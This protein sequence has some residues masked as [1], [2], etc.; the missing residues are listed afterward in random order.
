MESHMM[1][2]GISLI[3]DYTV[4]L[5]SQIPKYCMIA[6]IIPP[7]FVYDVC[8]FCANVYGVFRLTNYDSDC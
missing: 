2:V 4:S 1:H 3:N 6:N 8:Y 5:I 7:C